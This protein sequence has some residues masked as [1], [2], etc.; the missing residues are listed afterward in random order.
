MFMNLIHVSR[1]GYTDRRNGLYFSGSGSHEHDPIGQRD[2][3]DK[4]MSDKDDR[5]FRTGPQSEQLL[6][7]DDSGLGV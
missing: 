5:F 3:F 6:L 2:R 1:P 4:I 7:Q